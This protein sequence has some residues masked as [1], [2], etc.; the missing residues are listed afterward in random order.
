MRV[1]SLSSNSRGPCSAQATAS[2]CNPISCINL[3]LTTEVQPSHQCVR[4]IAWLAMDAGRQ[5]LQ[6]G[7]TM[8]RL[9]MS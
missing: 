7:S 2:L 3:H 9:R 5:V 6:P 1:R 8:H 4:P